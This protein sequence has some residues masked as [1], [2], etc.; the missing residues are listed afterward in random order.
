MRERQ[1]GFRF[2][3]PLI[4]LLI[5]LALIL[6][7]ALAPLALL[8]PIVTTLALLRPIHVLHPIHSLHVALLV[9]Q[10]RAFG[11]LAHHQLRPHCARHIRAPSII[12]SLLRASR[13]QITTACPTANSIPAS[14]SAAAAASS[15]RCTLQRPGPFLPIALILVRSR[16]CLVRPRQPPARRAH[17]HIRQ[18]RRHQ[19]VQVLEH[20]ES[21]AHRV[22]RQACERL[23]PHRVS[24]AHIHHEHV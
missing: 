6:V 14:T 18:Q 22:S 24:A 7:L 21:R 2:A 9:Q 4:L 13:I 3:L 16:Q 10:R 17:V 8:R 19:L 20:S 12:T 15:S 5:V 1:V 23:E 11:C